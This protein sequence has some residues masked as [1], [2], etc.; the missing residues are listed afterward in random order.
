MTTPIT[1]MIVDDHRMFREAIRT[2]LEEEPDMEVVAEA[3]TAEG[4]LEEVERARPTVVS[5]DIRL[6][7]MSGIEAARLLR[8]KVPDTKVLILTGYDFDQYVRAVARAGIQ[9]YMLKDSPL[10]DLVNAIREIAN[11]GT[12]LSPPIASK[13]IRDFAS[14]AVGERQSDVWELTVREIEVLEMLH[15]GLR[16]AEIGERLSI[17]TR[18][19]EVHVGNIISK[20]RAHNRTEAVRIALEKS[21]IR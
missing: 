13:V 20:L 11:G 15:E 21:M 1:V 14:P 19:V 12:V 10:T 9:G 4:A 18:T 8:E 2:R 7:N 3:S 6:P 16:N 5:L 17:S